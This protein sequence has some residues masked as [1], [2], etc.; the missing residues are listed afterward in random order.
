M[1]PCID[2]KVHAMQLFTEQFFLSFFVPRLLLLQFICALRTSDGNVQC[3]E[4]KL[5]VRLHMWTNWLILH[6][7]VHAYF[8]AVLPDFRLLFCRFFFFVVFFSLFDV[9][10]IVDLFCRWK[11]QCLNSSWREKCADSVLNWTSLWSVWRTLEF[12]SV[13]DNDEK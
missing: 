4:E 1:N 5:C 11:M 10:V 6:A 9:V 13:N 8:A 3:E 2:L 7:L 12:H